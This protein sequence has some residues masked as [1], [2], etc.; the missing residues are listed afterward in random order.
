MLYNPAP[1][2]SR[3]I[4][5]IS[6]GA[7]AVAL[8]ISA[9]PAH[10]Q[11]ADPPLFGETLDPGEGEPLIV[12]LGGRLSGQV[13]G[14]IP[15]ELDLG[16]DDIA[17]YGASSIQDLLEAI[18]PQ[19]GSARGRGGG[20]RPIILLNGQRISSFRELR[21]LPPEAIERV[22]V[23]PEELA[24]RY[25]FRPDQRVVN[26]ILKPNFA[27]IAGEV[28]HG[29]ATQ[30]GFAMS[31][32]EATLTRIGESGRLNID[33]EYQRE[34]AILESERDIVQP[35]IDA[36]GL[37]DN[38]DFRTLRGQ[39]DT[40]EFNATYSRRFSENTTATLSA[41]YTFEDTVAQ[42]GLPD[43]DLTVPA[44]SPFAQSPVDEMITRLLPAIGGTLERF[45]T[46]Q[47]AEAGLT[48]NGQ[49]GDYRWAFT[50]N[51]SREITE[52]RTERAF[53]LTSLQT[54]IAA[55]DPSLDPFAADLG[56]GLGFTRDD[57]RGVVQNAD[58][59]FN[60]TGSP[61]ALPAGP[62]NISLTGGF[63]W[64][65]IDSRATQGGILSVADLDR[66]SGV[67]RA[68]VDIPLT[69]RSEGFLGAIGDIS[70]NLNIGYSE[71]SDFG[72]LL[73]YGYG[74]NWE[75]IDGLT[76]LASIIGEEAAPTVQQLGNPI[77]ATPGVSAFDFTNGESVLV[78][79]TTGG[80]PAL[81]GEDRRDF[82]LGVNFA[83]G[84]SSEIRFI[85]E[86][87]NNDSENVTAAFPLLTP[88]IEA[89]FPDRVTRNGAG[90]LIAIDA[91]PVNFAETRAERI[92]YGMNLSGRIGSERER[93]GRGGPPSGA[94]RA[95]E[96][97][98]ARASRGPGRPRGRPSR[99]RLS[100]F[101]TYRLDETVL[102]RPGVAELDLLDGSVTAS[103][104][105]LA[106]HSVELEGGFF[107]N[108]IGMRVNAEY[109]G[110]A[111]IDGD[112]LL[113]TDSLFF[114]DLFKMNVRAFFNFDSR[115]GL[116]EDVPFLGGARLALRVDN[117]FGGIR[118]VTDQNGDVPL[119]YQPGF[120]DPRG[121]YIELSF[122][123]RF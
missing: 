2:A 8:L 79:R 11:N 86:Y 75:P 102:I 72:G 19:T 64:R 74:I 94:R 112:P 27:A 100:V 43:V 118:R 109:T 41:E 44:S 108:G 30:G 59:E 9:P 55:G 85:A 48:V 51:Y 104:T 17:A 10:A 62:V 103:D 71:F 114:R 57:A 67:G 70:L 13:I 52:T 36:L 14:D 15:A 31:E 53:G 120:I 50:G 81:L 5:A 21:D 98:E 46:E 42:L 38:A 101:H 20:G 116:V 29:M 105:P 32:I 76:F 83:P 65:A 119:A 115:P 26:F 88:E 47:N 54:R 28:E 58:A 49:L 99:W 45:T 77:I 35:E 33:I 69:S 106:R 1:R 97:G 96:S 107:H 61:F 37:V 122:R 117:L 78:E 73:E 90:T 121:R 3:G 25:G 123:K 82:K 91:R 6:Y 22:Q 84:D 40:V 7:L 68:S 24:I 66:T 87:I 95:G 93:R 63:E 110:A 23:F 60:I 111:R 16:E 12:V 113:G 89:A 4:A 56:A 39:K 92:R 34:G 18:A 80:N